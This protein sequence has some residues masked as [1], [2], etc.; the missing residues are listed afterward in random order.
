MLSTIPHS[1]V[2]T[3]TNFAIVDMDDVAEY[4]LEAAF[5]LARIAFR[6]RP[7]GWWQ[8]SRPEMMADTGLGERRLERALSVLRGR[9][10]IEVE[11]DPTAWDRTMRYRRSSPMRTIRPHASGQSVLIEQD[12]SSSS[13]RTICPPAP[14][15]KGKE[16]S[17]NP[18]RGDEDGLFEVPA[19]PPPKPPAPPEGFTEWWSAYPRKVGK[20]DAERAYSRAL[21]DGAT[22]PVLM[23]GLR[24]QLA[25]F[26]SRP[27]DKVPHPTTWL[28]GARWE[29][30][31]RPADD[32]VP[33][34]ER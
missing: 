31:V 28:N 26:R 24:A 20:R 4:G 33:W 6:A 17:S 15:R 21:K 7:D 12:N 19:A 3:S 14:I 22:A 18:H 30:E 1:P 25:D 23:A 9:G 11:Q 10:V 16:L 8:I 13:M 2:T 27:A 29:D 5:L 34:Y 32:G